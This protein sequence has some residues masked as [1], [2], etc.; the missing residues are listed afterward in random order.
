[1]V[2]PA[3]TPVT[4]PKLEIVA[5]AVFEEIQG[6]FPASVPFPVSVNVLPTQ[7]DELP[8]M[9]GFGFTVTTAVT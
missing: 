8:V 5:T 3:E 1:M 2:F 9:I 6:L 7:R 4:T